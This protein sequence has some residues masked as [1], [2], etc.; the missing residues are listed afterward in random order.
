MHDPDLEGI[1]PYIPFYMRDG[2]EV[3]DEWMESFCSG[4]RS[5]MVTFIIYK[6]K[7]GK[8]SEP[9]VKRVQWL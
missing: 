3:V 1:V 4:D 6:N 5:G 8:L 9:I 2:N 7:K